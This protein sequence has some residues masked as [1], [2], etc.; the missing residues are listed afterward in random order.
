MSDITYIQ[1]QDGFSFLIIIT[2]AYSRKIIGFS[3]DKTLHTEGCLKALKTALMQANQVSTKNLI[4]HSDRGIQYCSYVYIEL[5][6][7]H[8]IQ[9]SMSDKGSPQQNAIAERVN[10]ILKHEF[11]LK[12]TF[13]SHQAVFKAVAEAIR[14]YNKIRPHSSCDYL[15]A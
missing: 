6:K 11:G 2:D 4:H 1:T 14:K 12:K 8:N 9:I 5:L 15:I 7:T 10:G 3:T 13:V